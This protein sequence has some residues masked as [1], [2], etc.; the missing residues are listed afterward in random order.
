MPNFGYGDP[1]RRRGAAFGHGGL[2][3][4]GARRGRGPHE[5]VVVTS[6]YSQGQG[7]VCRVLATVVARVG[8]RSRTPAIRSSVG[9]AT[10]VRP[11]DRAGSRSTRTG[12]GSRSCRGQ[13][14]TSWFSPR[15]IS[16]RP[17]R[18]SP[19]N[20]DRGTPRMAP[21]QRNPIAIE[22]DYDAEYRYDRARG[23]RTARAGVGPDHL[24][25]LG[26]QDTRSGAPAWL[27]RA[28][29]ESDGSREPL[30]RTPT[31]AGR[32]A[33]SSTPSR[34]S[35]RVVSSTATCGG[36]APGTGGDEICWSRPSRTRS[37]RRK[38]RGIAAGLHVTAELPEDYDEQAIIDE[39]HRQRRIDATTM[40]K[41]WIEP[42]TLARRRCCSATARSQ[43]PA[44]SR[45]VTAGG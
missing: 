5:R 28:T 6:G 24:C 41:F 44:I 22:D 7:I 37:P 2:S 12:S 30:R 25:R 38:V 23:R 19:A 43:E 32:R 10:H 34:T 36:C 31:T 35:S 15:P 39:V 16:T 11:R 3:R 4:P 45:S 29:P 33:S 14:S 40:R 42:S 1:A 17:A 26:E 18:C 20:G 13:M 9:I 21:P 8:S 27:A